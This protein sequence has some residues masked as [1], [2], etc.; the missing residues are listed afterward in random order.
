LWTFSA[1]PRKRCPLQTLGFAG[2]FLTRV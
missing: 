1:N 2:R